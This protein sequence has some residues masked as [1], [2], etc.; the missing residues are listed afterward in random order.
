MMIIKLIERVTNIPTMQ[1][2]TGIFQVSHFY[3]Y[4]S[5]QDDQVAII[6][7]I[8]NGLSSWVVHKG[9]NFL[10]AQIIKADC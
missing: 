1:F 5:S 6:I 10:L 9:S 3:K 2:R 4:T 8:Y 7:I